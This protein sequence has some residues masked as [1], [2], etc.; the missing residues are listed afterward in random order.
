MRT[1]SLIAKARLTD[2]AALEAPTAFDMGTIAG[3]DLLRLPV[4]SFESGRRAD[5]VA[6]DLNDL[7]LFP[8]NVLER[9]I[10][11]SM[12]PTA[13]ARVMVAGEVIVDSGGSSRMPLRR[14]RELVDDVTRSW[15]R[16]AFANVPPF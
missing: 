11:S 7:S 10:V 8:R 5:V 14:V 3:A 4:G 16:S 15:N 6:L 13:I 1:A 2:G 12:Q 9:T